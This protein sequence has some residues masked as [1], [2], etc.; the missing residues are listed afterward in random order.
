MKIAQVAP[1]NESIPPKTYGGTER[2]VHYLTEELV[3]QGHDVTLYASA[4]SQS[5]AHTHAIIP[6]SLRTQKSNRHPVAAH[7]LQMMSLLEELTQYDLVHF[8]TEYYQFMLA[9][10]ISVPHLSTMHCR[11]DTTDY[12]ALFAKHPQMPVVSISRAHARQAPD[13]NWIGTVYNGIPK[14]NYIF[15]S[16]A[17]GGYLLFVGRFSPLKNPKGAI[18]IALA[19][20]RPLK[21]AAKLD[22]FDEPY[23]K[24]Y[25]RP[26][27]SHP[28][29]EYL[30][31]I[32]EIEKNELMG[33]AD[34]LLFPITWPEPFGLV[35]TE[36]MA[37]GTPVIAYERGAVPEVM[38][39]GKTGYIVNTIEAAKNAVNN[40]HLINRE[41]CRQH[42]EQYFSAERMTE[43]YNRL[44]LKQVQCQNHG[45][46]VKTLRKPQSKSTLAFSTPTHD[47]TSQTPSRSA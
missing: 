34:A 29:V 1:L 18:D 12:R 2:I 39:D 41:T 5:S 8:H 37:C 40:L 33:S 31:E 26:F 7:T 21:I 46:R 30:G 20:D 6:H 28:L 24:E 9:P 4:D 16:E 47:L 35:M 43:S 11:L 42:F 23:F 17:D 27:L 19:A 13:A 25:V 36:A 44:Y 32:N 22:S 45:K 10:F 38:V 3:A 15:Q 14:E